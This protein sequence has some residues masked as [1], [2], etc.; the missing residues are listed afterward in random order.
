[1]RL[2]VIRRVIDRHILVNYSVAGRVSVRVTGRGVDILPSWVAGVLCH[3]RPAAV[4]RPRASVPSLAGRGCGRV[5][6]TIQ[7]LRQPGGVPGRVHRVR[8][9]VADARHRARA[10]RQV[11]RLLSCGDAETGVRH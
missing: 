4:P 6:G 10:A 8:L 1:M 11:G 7:L 3:S 5:G 2:P 9:R